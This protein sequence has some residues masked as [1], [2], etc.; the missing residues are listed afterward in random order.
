[1]P[2]WGSEMQEIH[3]THDFAPADGKGA[4]KLHG[5]C[6]PKAALWIQIE[7]AGKIAR[8]SCGHCN[9]FV[10]GLGLSGEIYSIYEDVLH[11]GPGGKNAPFH[12][13]IKGITIDLRETADNKGLAD[14][15]GRTITHDKPGAP[16]EIKADLQKITSDD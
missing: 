14:L 3:K 2:D 12:D 5:Q 6:H 9:R 15:I 13:S 10:A 1:M 7:E 8:L 4:A 11:R 16:V